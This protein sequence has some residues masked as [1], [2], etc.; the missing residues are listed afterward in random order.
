M[1]SWPGLYLPPI[2]ANYPQLNLFSTY[3]AKLV[4]VNQDL[5]IDIY[6]CGITPY[7]STHCGHAATYITFDLI[8]RYLKSAGATVNFIENIT[9]IDDPLLERANRD[10]QDWHELAENQIDLFRS[11]MVALHVLPPTSYIGAIESM[12]EVFKQIAV[13]QAA[14][15]TYEIDGDLYLSIAEC[16]GS[17]ENLPFSLEESLRIFKERGGDPDRVGKKHPLDTLLWLKG[18]PNEPAWESP[19]GAGRPGWHIEC[20]AIALKY[21]SGNPKFT[22]TIQ[23]GGSDL[24]FPHHYMSGVQGRNLV[25]REFAEIYTHTGM[26]GLAGEKMSK[27]KGNLVFV[28]TLLAEGVDPVVI[29]VN[30]MQDR[31]RDDRMWSGTGLARAEEKVLRIRSALSREEVAPT[32]PL[33]NEIISALSSDLDTPKVFELVDRWCFDTEAGQSGGSAGEIARAF[34]ALLGLTF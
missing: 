27:S 6:V 26:I 11:D 12:S 13:F 28:S 19:F 9:D 33:I 7:D 2:T 21:A 25:N 10:G 22:L 5:P 18:R 8:H 20:A 31:Y 29:R 23:G 3:A 30:L 15:L 4:G 1:R 24:I 16:P 17:L 34:D 14:N 32:K